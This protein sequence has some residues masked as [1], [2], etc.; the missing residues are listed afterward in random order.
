MTFEERF[1][2]DEW[3]AVS[4]DSAARACVFSE[5][6]WASRE[7]TTRVERS[8]GRNAFCPRRRL[9]QYRV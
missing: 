9:R 7:W 6:A 8:E 1:E 5:C 4:S 2:M 3:R